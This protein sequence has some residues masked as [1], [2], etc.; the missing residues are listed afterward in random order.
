M[1]SKL[2]WSV[3]W[4]QNRGFE[5][6]CPGGHEG[7]MQSNPLMN[8]ATF[9]EQEWRETRGKIG[10]GQSKCEVCHPRW[11]CTVCRGRGTIHAKTVPRPSGGT[12]G[13]S[14]T[15]ESVTHPPDHE[16]HLQ[17]AHVPREDEGG[18]KGA[19]ASTGTGSGRQE[20]CH[21]QSHVARLRW[22]HLPDCT[23]HARGDQHNN[24]LLCRRLQSL[25]QVWNSLF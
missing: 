14:H 8:G 23:A 1:E 21:L 2:C 16:F 3:S 20:P 12:Q 7:W 18:T 11:W 17:P 24:R 19:A 5:V 10:G 4:L 6:D 9:R 15:P 13:R 22:Q 25:S